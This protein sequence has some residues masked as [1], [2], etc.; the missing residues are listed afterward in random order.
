MMKMR[1]LIPLLALSALLAATFGLAGCGG[2]GNGN[3]EECPDGQ[4]RC[5]DGQCHE[6]CNNDHCA[7]DEEC[8]AEY[9]C[10]PICE[11]EG[12]DCSDDPEICCEGL[13][14]DPFSDTCMPVC[15]ADADCEASHGDVDFAADLVCQDNGTCDFQKCQRD[16]NC[17]PGTVCYNGDCVTPADCAQVTSC[18]VVPASV[19][20][21]TGTTAAFSATA[22]LS[23][24]ALAPGASFSWSSSDDAIAA[25]SAGAVTGGA[26][27]GTATITATVTGCDT[28]CTGEVLNYGAVE[29]GV[30]VVAVNELTREP[31][32]GITV[33]I[34]GAAAAVDT[35]ADG[36]A[37]FAD[38]DLAATPADVTLSAADVGYVSFMQADSNDLIAHLG[39]AL[40]PTKV[41]GYTGKFDFS[42]VECDGSC[43]V[44]L[45]FTGASIPGNL[46][47]LNVDALIGEMIMTHIELGG[48]SED[49]EL[50]G[51]LVI[52][53]NETWFR[54]FY[55]ATGTPG[56][57]VAWG[58]GGMLNLAD[59]I[60]V[61]GPVISGGEIDI[62]A[63]LASVLPMFSS[64][65][66]G[67]VPNVEIEPIDKVA[68]V[69]DINGDGDTTDLVPDYDSFPELPGGDM[70]LKVP[71]N[72]QMTI[73]VPD[74]PGDGAGGYLYDGVVVLA[75]VMV[76]DAGLVP[77]G[78]TAGMDAASQDDSPD[79]SIADVSLAAS[80]VAGRLPEGTYQRVV[81]AL[82]LNIGK[83]TAE[84]NEDP[85]V[86]SGQVHFVDSFSG[87]LTLNTF[88][89][90]AGYS[91]DAGTRELTVDSVPADA[92][93][94][95]ALASGDAGTW[96]ILHPAETGAITLPAAPPAGDR[97][98]GLGMGV[99][100]M[101][102]G[103]TYS[104]LIAFNDD[105]LVDL[106]TLISDFVIVY[107]EGSGGLDV[108]CATGTT[109]GGLLGLAVMLLGLAW[110]RR[111]A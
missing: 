87:S 67:L 54:E 41:G 32:A 11:E 77:L 78:L 65:Y 40:D 44:K 58:L 110:L 73:S 27:T 95:L 83:L 46:F 82:A 28:T 60:E 33:E 45:G 94:L 108:S 90:P 19:V 49:V 26:T 7:A 20:T 109:K 37:L 106:V 17:R 36:V 105:N 24:G 16:D 61:L 18:K 76:R 10:K 84:D 31:L 57:R 100:K 81:V 34:A 97:L 35:D 1:K 22:F 13:A 63:I 4:Y 75:G 23:S 64:F 111:R 55:Q 30:R 59:L 104:D 79:G 3:G 102:G 71:M 2:G 91:F 88:M 15:T 56:T 50:P 62:G 103:V 66:T 5:D 9:V 72:E 70:K 74:M 38:M 14:C 85:L 80:D 68:D 12:A 107:A 42:P 51:G 96:Q 29:Q 43:E 92:D 99:M 47:N 25:V 93:A 39:I 21:Q 48:T 89:E 8:T 6:C 86:L 98:D 53:L 52:G 69:D 101:A